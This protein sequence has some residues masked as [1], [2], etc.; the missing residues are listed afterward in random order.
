M[1][2]GTHWGLR[3]MMRFVTISKLAAESGYTERA[4]R[5]KIDR[6]DWQQGQVWIRAPDGRILID[7]EGFERWARGIAVSGRRRRAV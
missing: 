1:S 3:P 5:A 6:G 2:Y 4:V 7:R